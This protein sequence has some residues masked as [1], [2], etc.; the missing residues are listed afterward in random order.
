MPAN[1][2]VLTSRNVILPDFAQPQHA[3]IK[4]NVISGKITSIQHVYSG[5]ASRNVDEI[6]GNVE[7]ID[8]GDKF[9]L[10]G[11]VEF[12]SLLLPISSTRPHCV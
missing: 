8:V 6:P 5:T 3:T 4:V 11:L 9:I 2:L 10:P 1:T 12:V 7:W